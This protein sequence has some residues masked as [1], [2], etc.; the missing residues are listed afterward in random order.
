[1]IGVS[2]MYSEITAL[3]GIKD[4]EIVN[5][6]KNSYNCDYLI[7]SKGY[8]DRVHKLNPNSK[9]IEINS[10]T[11]L[12]LIESLEKLKNEHIGDEFC[13]NQSIENL[14]KLDSKIKNDNFEFIK[15]FEYGVSSNSK[16]ITKIIDDLGFEHK[17]ERTIQIIPDYN[18]NDDLNLNDK[19]ILKTH[20]Y[21]LGLIERIEDRYMSILSSLNGI[22]PRKTL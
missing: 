3:S 8:F 17:N 16:F 4:F 1:M 7:I 22:I 21:D 10:A 9:I 19:I 14:K 6:Y 12:D 11:F 13:I 20:R 15:N 18:L 2:K 5:P